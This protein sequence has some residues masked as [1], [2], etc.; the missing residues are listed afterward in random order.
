MPRAALI[1]LYDTLVDG[2][3]SWWRA[4]LARR[5]GATEETVN[6]AFR[7]TRP[8]RNT[9]AYRDQSAEMGAVVAAAGVEPDPPLIRELVAAERAFS[10]ERVT[11]FPDALPVV[12][13]LR[14]RGVATV[15]VSNCSHNTMVVVEQL[16]LEDAFDALILSFQV[17]AAKPDR[18]IYLAALD[19]VGARP[20]DAVF[21]DDQAAYVDGAIALG[22]DARLILRPSM[23]P[24]EGVSRADGH[25]TISDLTALLGDEGQRSMPSSSHR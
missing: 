15:L 14:A 13:E 4:H 1:D 9:G 21:V 12:A 7:S 24:A 18:R 17:R 3:W 11:P 25:R 19:A 6:E 8:R 2:D 5:L 23:E 10:A 22:I 16:R 20:Q